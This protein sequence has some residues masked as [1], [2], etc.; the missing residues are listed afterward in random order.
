[1]A[2]FPAKSFGYHGDNVALQRAARKRA[3]PDYLSVLQP[4]DNIAD[5]AHVCLCNHAGAFAAIFQNI[6]DIG[7]IGHQTTHFMGDR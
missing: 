1:M 2:G 7:W 5:V 4:A 6:V 3:A